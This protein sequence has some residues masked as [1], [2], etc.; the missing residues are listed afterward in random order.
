VTE[1]TVN[2]LSGVAFLCLLLGGGMAVIQ[3]LPAWLPMALGLGALALW[4][5][6]GVAYCADQITQ[7]VH[8]K[9][10]PTP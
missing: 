1:R 7:L 10:H 6:L 3:M 9:G 8:R 2:R 4:F 5:A